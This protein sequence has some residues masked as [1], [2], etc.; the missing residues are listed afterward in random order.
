MYKVH[1][2][3]SRYCRG[4]QCQ[5]MI[6]M[7][8]YNPDKKTKVDNE[9]VIKN[10]DI[11]KE[12]AKKLFGKIEK[13]E[14]DTEITKKFSYTKEL[15]EKTPNVISDAFFTDDDSFCRVDLLKNDLDEI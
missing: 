6:W 14:F 3:K 10:A 15:L 11:V 9:K 4:R 8:L 5:K 7:D 13:V 2:S 1:L 12:Y